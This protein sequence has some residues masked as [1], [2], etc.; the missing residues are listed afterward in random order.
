MRSGVGNDV[1]VP[2]GL[3]GI[4][5]DEGVDSG[6]SDDEGVSVPDG[7]EDIDAELECDG[8]MRRVGESDAETET[9]GEP[10]TDTPP[11]RDEVGVDVCEDV[12]LVEGVMDGEL[13]ILAVFEREDDDVR[14]E[15]GDGRTERLTVGVISLMFTLS[16]IGN[17]AT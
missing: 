8:E 2:L 10:D 9:E 12:M 16:A 17:M 6:V 5:D 3:W 1:R 7:V 15:E 13:V 11:V 4:K 14:F